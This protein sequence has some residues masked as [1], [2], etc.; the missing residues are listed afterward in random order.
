MLMPTEKHEKKLGKERLERIIEM[1]IAI[2]NHQV[3]PFTLNVDD[4]IAIVKIVFSALG[5]TRRAETRRRSPPPPC[6]RHQ[7]AE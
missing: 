3:D 4:I 1:C 7:D 2:E 5:P 6:I